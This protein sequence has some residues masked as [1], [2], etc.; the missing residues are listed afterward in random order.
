MTQELKK[1][2]EEFL[3][4]IGSD[5]GEKEAFLNIMDNNYWVDLVDK[6][7]HFL[8]I[9]SLGSGDFKLA[10]ILAL[11]KAWVKEQKGLEAE[12]SDPLGNRYL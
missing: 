12:N 11:L 5:F 2:F 6:S 1:D 7:I 3:S 9:V 4:K 8:G 10:G